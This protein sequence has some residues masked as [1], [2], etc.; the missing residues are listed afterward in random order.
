MK[1]KIFTHALI[2]LVFLLAIQSSAAQGAILPGRSQPGPALA[3]VL[4]ATPTTSLTVNNDGSIAYLVRGGDT[5]TAI[6]AQ[7]SVTVTELKAWNRIG[8]DN[9]V[10]SN[11]WLIVHPASTTTPTPPP[12]ATPSPETPT[13]AA[14]ATS[15]GQTITPPPVATPTPTPSGFFAGVPGFFSKNMGGLI[16]GLALGLVLGLF[17]A[18]FGRRR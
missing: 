5:L 18:Q 2:L 13:P 3:V 14:T 10:F 4:A 12:S 9:L 15:G 16:V 17:L 11:T 8:D 1:S 7:F 6:A